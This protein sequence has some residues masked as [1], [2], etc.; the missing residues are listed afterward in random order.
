MTTQT[1]RINGVLGDLG[2]KTPCRAASAGITLTLSGLQTVDGVLLASGDRLLVPSYRKRH[3]EGVC[4][5]E[6]ML[7]C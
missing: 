5:H 4:H 6:N 7:E 2:M 1:D 3:L